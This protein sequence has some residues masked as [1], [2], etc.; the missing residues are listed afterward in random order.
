MNLGLYMYIVFTRFGCASDLPT[1]GISSYSGGVYPRAYFH[2]YL[3]QNSP[4][5]RQT[6]A[7]VMYEPRPLH[8]Y[9]VHAVWLRFGSA[10]TRN[11]VILR[12]CVSPSLLSRI[13]RSKLTL[14]AP[15]QGLCDV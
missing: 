11:L 6:K 14:L 4:Y 3:A 8:V 10:D 13:S 2:E 12:R 7:C 1:R 9:S 15:N 5:S